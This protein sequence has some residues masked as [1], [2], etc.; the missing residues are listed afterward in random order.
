VAVPFGEWLELIDGE[1][2][3]DFVVEGGAAVKFVVSDGAAAE[4]VKEA[5]RRRA[6]AHGLFFA[7]VDSADVKL[8]LIQDLFFAVSRQTDWATDTQ[9]FVE[10][11]CR[12]NGY[13]W[14]RPEQTVAMTELAGHN[15]VDETILKKEFN[16]WLTAKVMRDTGLAQDFRIAMTRLCLNRLVPMDEEGDT[17]APILQWL[18]GELRLIGP[19]RA[20]DIYSKITRHNARSMLRSLCRWLR[21]VGHKGLLL[22]IDIR[23]VT[24]TAAAGLADIRYTPNA[25]MDA[26]EVLRQLIDD[27]DLFEGLF[28]VAMA[29]HAFIDGDAKR[30]VSAYTALKMR[31]WDDVRARDRDNPLA[32]MVIV[33][34]VQI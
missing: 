5:C 2:L 11:L 21:L 28:L 32:P 25:V 15:G 16:Q 24:Q 19:L 27:V 33:D 34:A 7:A 22:T 13:E 3:R 9:R 26:Y 17:E 30:S 29:D 6:R 14:P 4:A 8:H 10:A 18:R 1:Y 23:R 12:S 31:I 20:A